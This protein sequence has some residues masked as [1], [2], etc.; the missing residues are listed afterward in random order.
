[1]S[2]KLLEEIKQEIDQLPRIEKET[3]EKYY[4]NKDKLIKTVNDILA[5]R[6]NIE[7]LIGYN[8]LELMKENH[9]NHARFMGNVF[10]LNEYR[11]LIDTVPWVYNTYRQKGFSYKYF[12]QELKAWK[13]AIKTILGSKKTASILKIYDWLIENHD[14]FITIS[15]GLNSYDPVFEN[16][17][18]REFEIFLEALLM[19]EDK[20]AQHIAEDNIETKEDFREFTRNVIKPVMYTIGLMWEQNDIAPAEEHRATSIAA[21]ILSSFYTKY[22]PEQHSQGK[23]VVSA[24][25]N[26]H[27]E[28]GAR[29][30]ADCLEFD[31]WDVSFLGA[32]THGEELIDY[33]LEEKP[34]LLG[35]SVC[36]PYNL[37]ELKEIVEKIRCESALQGIKILVGGKAL[38]DFPYLLEKMKADDRAEDGSSALEIANRWWRNRND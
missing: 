30:I 2:E 31:G 11:M 32:D 24:V 14:K 19:G 4:A 26:E 35:L 21:R 5:D 25:A 15:Q 38:N 10:I 7:N 13:Q 18:E 17:D 20:K 12:H 28:L 9:E 34:F 33:L 29:I 37:K 27:H 8:P 23:A 6:D 22:L 36:V 16:E 1:M 3:G